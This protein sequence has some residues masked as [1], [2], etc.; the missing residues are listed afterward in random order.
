MVELL[1]G[2]QCICQHK[3]RP[4]SFLCP[5]FYDQTRSMQ[6]HFCVLIWFAAVLYFNLLLCLYVL[7]SLHLNP[8]RVCGC[9]QNMYRG[10]VPL[11]V[12]LCCCR[13]PGGMWCGISGW[14]T[15]TMISGR[16]CWVTRRHSSSTAWGPR[17]CRRLTHIRQ[18]N[19]MQLKVLSGKLKKAICWKCH[20]H[21][22]DF[23][24]WNALWEYRQRVDY[25]YLDM[26]H[27][28]TT[29]GWFLTHLGIA[30]RISLVNPSCLSTPGVWNATLN[31]GPTREGAVREIS[32]K[33][34]K[35][36]ALYSSFKESF[37]MPFFLHVVL[38][39]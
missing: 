2:W 29:A 33:I 16:L 22:I 31:S 17:R 14:G 27:F 25:P 11:I 3:H 12:Y 37:K 8:N 19:K 36:S 20:S 30:Y 26:S 15:E 10:C 34:F 28:S 1:S 32:F 21:A 18:A 6:T 35:V 39:F 4:L 5:F 13:K 9:A 23:S 24:L 38:M 7:F